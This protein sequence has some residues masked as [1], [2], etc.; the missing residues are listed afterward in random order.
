MINYEIFARVKLFQDIVNEDH[1]E[2]YEVS[3]TPVGRGEFRT[4]K[5]VVIYIN[6]LTK[7]ELKN[8]N[9]LLIEIVSSQDNRGSLIE[10]KDYESLSIL[11]EN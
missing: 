6:E 9:N 3:E 10:I 7:E 5:K 8:V 1:L 11:E 2:L 4:F